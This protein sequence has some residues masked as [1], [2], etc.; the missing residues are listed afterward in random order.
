MTPRQTPQDVLVDG[1]LV[2]DTGSAPIVIFSGT[3]TIVP[4]APGETIDL[5][6]VTIPPA[7]NIQ[8]TGL[9]IEQRLA[10]QGSGQLA[11]VEG[12]HITLRADVTIEIAA[13]SKE[14][15]KLDLGTVGAAGTA[16]PSEVIIDIPEGTVAAADVETFSRPVISGRTLNCEQWK[17][18]V[19]LTDPEHF[20]IHCETTA[21]GGKLL[22]LD[23]KSLVIKGKKK[24]ETP[25]PNNSDKDSLP[26]I[27]GGVGG[28][29]VV[30]AVIIVV[31]VCRRKS[32][33][34]SK[35]GH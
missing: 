14:I 35:S 20:E 22:D 23:E 30:I 4:P 6:D 10:L 26:Y 27:I 18:K 28:A 15:P 34:S 8:A 29:V 2:V 5:I 7:S 16:I 25:T 13:E 32:D 24:Q 12:D 19:I 9:V 17:P 21:S 33:D 31:V 11:A 1:E 3:G